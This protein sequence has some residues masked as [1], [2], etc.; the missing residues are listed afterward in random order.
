MRGGEQMKGEKRRGGCRDEAMGGMTAVCGGGIC[1]ILS[2]DRTSERYSIASAVLGNH[3]HQHTHTHTHG[4][5]PAKLIW[6]AMAA[7]PPCRAAVA[8]GRGPDHFGQYH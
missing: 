2:G 3:E 1:H 4:A 8:V 5:G 6:L 7:R